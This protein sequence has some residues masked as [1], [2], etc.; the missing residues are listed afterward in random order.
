MKKEY[1][2]SRM[3]GKKNPH[4]RRLKKQVT[5][6]LGI[7]VIA[8][9]KEMSETSGIPYQNL[10]NSYLTDCARNQRKLVVEWS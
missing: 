10:I 2:F 6:R 1:G 7:E 8:Y 9:F 5:M 3:S 4:A